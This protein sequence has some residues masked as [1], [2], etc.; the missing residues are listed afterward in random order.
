MA[1]MVDSHSSFLGKT[2]TYLYCMFKAMVAE[3]LTAQH[4]SDI[5]MS[6]MVSQITGISMVWPTVCSGA[7][8]R[9]H[10]SSAS[11]AFARGIQRF[12]LMTPWRKKCVTSHIIDLFVLGTSGFS[13]IRVDYLRRKRILWIIIPKELFAVDFNK[14]S[15]TWADVCEHQR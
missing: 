1:Q 10:Q 5:T 11:L 13:T 12:H 4:H 15:N 7:D 8:Q 14:Y 3:Y 6:A 9:K 2:K